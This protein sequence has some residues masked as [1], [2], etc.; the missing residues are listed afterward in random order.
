MSR[1]NVFSQWQGPRPVITVGDTQIRL[2]VFYHHNDVFM[3]VHAA[4]YDAVAAELPSEVIRPARWADGR[5]LVAVTAFRYHAVT[6][7]AG[8]GSAG[9]L[10]P[11]GEVSLAAVVTAGPARRVLPL[12]SGQLRGFVLHLP[13]TTIEARD[14]GIAGWGFPKFVA[15]MDFTEDPSF[16]RVCLSEGGSPILTLTV[17]PRGPVLA[18]RRPLVAYTA[19]HGELLETVIPVRGHMQ[20]R[21]GGGELLLGDHEVAHRLRRLQ[22]SPASLAVFSYLDHRS[23]LP[24]GQSAGPARDYHGYTGADQ[25]FGRFTVSYPG[26]PPLDQYAAA[27]ALSQGERDKVG[28]ATRRASW[29]PVSG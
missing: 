29:G 15:D 3:S 28:E 19:L 25:A 18:E 7:S 16:R 4:S 21:P 17:R 1:R 9:S 8:D 13:V 14:G 26:T 12:L 20:A 11:Y 6:W 23:I 10:A 27:P 22:I 24:V 2:P 5:A